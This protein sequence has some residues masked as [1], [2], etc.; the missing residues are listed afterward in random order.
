MREALWTL[1][2]GAAGFAA[3]A[4]AAPDFA[5]RYTQ[6]ANFYSET[7]VIAHVPGGAYS[8]KIDLDFKGCRGTVSATG[9]VEGESL[10]ATATAGGRET[11]RLEIRYE[12]PGVHV[13]EQ[14]CAAHHG[15]KC[16]FSSFLKRRR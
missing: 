6:P 16:E 4:G 7:A 10:V 5:G 3:P 9:R 13:F 11:C 8:V 12:P 2:I 15:P 1:A 14:G